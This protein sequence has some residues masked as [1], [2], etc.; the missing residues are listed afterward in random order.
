[1][2]FP[3]AIN[4]VLVVAEENKILRRIC[5][6]GDGVDEKLEANGFSPSNV[7]GTVDS[8]PTWNESPC[9]PLSANDNADADARAGIREG[10]EVNGVYGSRDAPAQEGEGQL[11]GPP[12]KIRLYGGWGMSWHERTVTEDSNMASKPVR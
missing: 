1:V 10:V 5:S 3:P 9:P 4:D 6:P 7:P 8:L 12:L 11:S 2:V